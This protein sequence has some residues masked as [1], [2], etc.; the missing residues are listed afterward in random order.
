MTVSTIEATAE[1][2]RLMT[3]RLFA[4]LF[5][6]Q[7]LAAFNDNFLK[8][9]LVFLVVFSMSAAEA[10]PIVAL[11]SAIFIAPFLL[12]SALGGQIADRYDMARVAQWLKLGEVAAAGFAVAGL[13]LDSLTLL[14][15]SLFLFGAGS[16]LFSPVKY[17]ILPTHLE[18]AELPRANAW[19]E[20]GT[21]V[22]ILAGTIFA[23]IAVSA[24]GNTTLLAALLVGLSLLCW[25]ISRSIP[26]TG[27]A[28]PDL[29][30][31]RNIL[32]S[33]LQLLGEWRSDQRLR[34]TGLMVGWFW[35]VGAFMLTM[36]PIAVKDAMGGT[37]AVVTVYLAVF[38]VAVGLGSALVAW[39]AAGRIA[40]LPAP[41]GT[42]L[43]AAFGLDLALTLDSVSLLQ[44]GPSLGVFFSRPDSWRVAVDLAGMAIGAALLSVPSFAAL[45]AWAPAGRRSRVIAAV[46][47]LAA[48]F[49]AAGGGGVALTQVSS[50]T[51]AMAIAGF[52]LV[53]AIAAVVMLVLLPTNPLR[54]LLAMFFRVFHRVEISGLENLEKAGENPILALNHVSFLDAP[55]ALTLTEREPV[56]AIDRRIARQWWMAPFLKLVRALPLDPANPLATR[57][58]VKAVKAGEPLVIFPEGRLTVTGSLMKVYDGAAMIADKSGAKIVPVRL[59]GLEKSRFSRLKPWQ[60]RQRLFPKIKVTLLEP[61]TLDI[62]EGLKGRARRTAAGAELYR[63]M[64]ELLFR[65]TATERT[66]LEAVVETAK[67]RGLDQPAVED[68]VTGRLSYGKLL[69]GAAVLAL[70]F[71]RRFP[72][73]PTLGVMLPSANGAAATVLGLLSAGKVPAMINFTAGSANI[74]SA[75]K[76]AVVRT[77][78]TSRAFVEQARLGPVIEEIADQVRIC[79]L[80]DLRA[81]I[82]FTDKL[83]GLL[84]KTKP[85]VKSKPSDPAVIL[86]TSGSEGAPKGVVLSHRNILANVAQAASRIDFNAD[87]KLFNVLPVFHSFGLTAGLV[88]PLVSGVPVY[89]YPS[90]LHYRLVPE[91]IYGANATILFG[92]DSFLTGYARCA[93]PYDFRALRYCFAGAEPVKAATR[94]TYMEKFGVRILEGYGVT[95]A[96]PVI[97]IN[98][99][100]R[101]K[102]G[103]VGTL[104]PGIEARLE[105]V[106]GVAEGGRLFVRGAN[107]MA[108]YL[109]ADKP[110]VLEPPRDGWHDTGDIVRLDPDGFLT[111][112]GRAKRFAKIGGEMVSLAAV[113]ALAGE[114]WPGV[115]SAVA[116]L[117]DPR[118]GERLVL[119]TEAPGATR[120]DFLRFAKE[121]GAADLM[122]PA[123]VVVE[124]VPLLGSGKVDFGSVTRLVAARQTAEA[125]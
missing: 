18:K 47:A 123:E 3:S 5:W 49:I 86:F 31:D 68:P 108:G 9:V 22:A 44:G 36:L 69:T 110:G 61:V 43:I 82:G 59:D 20:A 65:T 107:V 90:P 33:T 26:A 77:V 105:P 87:D 76:A 103:T 29:R 54:D 58:L 55:L 27:S 50:V 125:A 38:T 8:N 35:L 85:R 46:N 48:L 114:L 112:C 94:E 119:V 73:E 57:S 71:E 17:A 15:L 53:N 81:E 111:I 45:Q 115:P 106:P 24:G 117:P 25:W 64:S 60:I 21:F 11:A 116:T 124:S 72:E 56:F 98:T 88:L 19:L 70:M 74:L 91:L 10:A 95:E 2:K 96:A 52:A 32:R 100:M 39:L 16:A 92:T 62:D 101:N 75:C 34:R 109:R 83:R 4:P 51:P 12:L 113:E 6:T 63:V 1:P 23:G 28:A 99:P 118:K 89:L 79:Y 7:F 37:E 97:A 30:I 80:E 66:I 104:M 120:A 93:H 14:M 40:L 13:A 122:V 121:R 102:A 84:R 78:L 42:L 67:E 41:I